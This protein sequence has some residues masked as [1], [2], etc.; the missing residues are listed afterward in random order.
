MSYKYHIFLAEDS[1]A[2]VFLVRHSLNESGLNYNLFVFEDGKSAATLL[3]RLGVDVPCPDLLLMD[4]NLPKI[5]GLELIQMIRDHHE[6]KEVPVIVV[7]SSDSPKDRDRA[8]Q[9]GISEYF[10]KPSSLSDFLKLGSLIRNVLE[11]RRPS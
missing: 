9:A 4:L 11:S 5:D 1:R 6:C 7:T 3:D 10:R 2:D 8:A